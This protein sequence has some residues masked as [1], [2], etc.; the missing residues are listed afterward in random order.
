M[1]T[2]FTRKKIPDTRKN[3]GTYCFNEGGF[4][5][6]KR[7]ETQINFSK[8]DST[9]F[10]AWHCLFVSYMTRGMRHMSWNC[11]SAFQ[12]FYNSFFTFNPLDFYPPRPLHDKLQQYVTP[13]PRSLAAPTPPCPKYG[14]RDP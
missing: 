4:E 7:H 5:I 10:F 13:R 1:Y 11:C 12:D 6:F 3:Y 2:A 9:K 8:I 14:G